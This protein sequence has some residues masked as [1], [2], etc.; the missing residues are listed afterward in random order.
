MQD[1]KIYFF[2]DEIYVVCI[3]EEY[4][5]ISIIEILD[6]LKFYYNWS[7]VYIIYGFFKDLGI[8]GF[9][10]GVLYFWYKQVLEVVSWMV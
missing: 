5:F 4:V 7:Y 10:V 8:V 6:I 3:Y 9:R 2:V 1:K